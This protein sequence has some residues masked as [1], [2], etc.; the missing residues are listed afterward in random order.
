M[1]VV[2]PIRGVAIGIT[3]NMSVR[4]YA[5]ITVSCPGVTIYGPVPPIDAIIRLLYLVRVIIIPLRVGWNDGHRYCRKHKDAH[6]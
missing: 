6:Q 4:I 3:V 2:M 5:P 1:A